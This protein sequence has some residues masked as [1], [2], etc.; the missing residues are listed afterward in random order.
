MDP[1]MSARRPTCVEINLEALRHN[2][3]QARRQAGEGRQ[4][5][6]V[7][8]ADAYGHGA[9]RVAMTLQEAGADLFGVAMVEEGVELRRAGIERPV[10]VLG[11]IYHG[12]EE[13][14]LRHELTPSLFDLQA[15]HR[16]D[17]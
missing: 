5:L 13:A 1:I 14:I 7:V 3:D 17:R 10:L 8:K 2:L 16:L 11:G 9:S 12:Q 15:A 4:V 6:A